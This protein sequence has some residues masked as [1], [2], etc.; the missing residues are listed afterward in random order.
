MAMPYCAKPKLERHQLTLFSPSLDD[1]LQDDHPARILDDLIN[2]LDVSEFEK[3]YHIGRGQPPIHPRV[4]IKV[5]LYAMSRRIRSSRIMEYALGYHVDFM[6]L[7]QMQQIDHSTLCHFRKKY[8]DAL[9]KLFR[10]LGKLA[11]SMGIAKLSEVTFD[12]TRVRA[13]NNVS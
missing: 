4:I 3:N 2:A 11:I 7:A 9:K 10:D 5:L 1:M 13:N 12:G 6:W 8:Y